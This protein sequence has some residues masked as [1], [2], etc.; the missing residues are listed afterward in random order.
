MSVTVVTGQVAR[1]GGIAIGSEQTTKPAGQVNMAVV[2]GQDENSD[3]TI[4]VTGLA[5]GDRIVGV[6]VLTTAASIA[7]V[8]QK[9]VADLSV[10]AGNVQV[11]AN[12][13]NNSANQYI[14]F[15]ED[16]T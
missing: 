3:N 9:T 13:A 15:W 10:I 6:L 2:A 11:D 12:K 14:I 5:V 4:P 8:A 16:R 1:V 7:T